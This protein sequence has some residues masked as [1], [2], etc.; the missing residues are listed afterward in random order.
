HF[1]LRQIE[2][3]IGQP[4]SEK[5]TLDFF[6]DRMSSVDVVL[7]LTEF[8]CWVFMCRN[9]LKQ[10]KFSWPADFT[11]ASWFFLFVAHEFCF[12]WKFDLEGGSSFSDR[13]NRSV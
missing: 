4:R 11:L 2:T 10:I 12:F 9:S 1:S 13:S 7:D 5:A 8:R 3:N 6:Q